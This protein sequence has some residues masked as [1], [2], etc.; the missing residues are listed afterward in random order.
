MTMNNKFALGGLATAR[1][2]IRTEEGRDMANKRFQLDQKEADL[3]KDGKLTKYEEA[4]GEAVQKAVANDELVEEEIPGMNCGG[5]MAP[6]EMMDPISG[7][8]IPLGSTAENVRDDLPAMLSEGEYVL[9]AHVVKWHGLKHIQE[10]QME[11]E[12]GLMGMYAS[13]LIKESDY[14]DEEPDSE[15][16]EDAEIS[17][18]DD[19][20]EET[21]EEEVETPEGNEIEVAGVEATEEDTE[22]EEEEGEYSK[23]P[24]Y[25]MAKNKRVVFIA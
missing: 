3:D 6:E 14:E 22:L 2:G 18:E 24:V 12:M 15:S 25:G 5:M 17:D 1:K 8:M 20:V 10:M 21:S 9:P 13:D 16:V 23:K 4:R 7:N 11:A 19:T